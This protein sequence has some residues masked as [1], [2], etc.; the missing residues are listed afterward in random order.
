[1]S[2]L[3]PQ[4]LSTIRRASDRL[5]PALAILPL[6]HMIID[7]LSIYTAMRVANVAFGQQ[8]SASVIDSY[9]LLAF[10]P[11]VL[12]GWV[13]DRGN[14]PRAA[15][16][17]GAAM[18]VAAAIIWPW[19]PLLA[20]WFAGLGNAVFHVA[21]GS[22]CLQHASGKAAVG[23]LFVGPGDLGVVLGTFIGSG[24]WP[25]SQVLI[26]AGILLTA[27]VAF[28][29]PPAIPQP[30]PHRALSGTAVGVVIL[31]LALAV[32]CRQLI[33]GVVG[34]QWPWFSSPRE[35]I[36]IAAVAMVGKMTLGF[37]ADRWGWMRV[38]VPLTVVAA[39]L[40]AV[41]GYLPATLMATL[42]VQAAMPVTLA[43][44]L[45]VMPRYPALAFGIA[46]T[47]LWV[48]SLP[49]V[50]NWLPWPPAVIAAVQLAAGLALAVVLMM[51]KP[52]AACERSD[53]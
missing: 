30:T 36:A 42:L 2:T 33:G 10:A 1:M 31:L 23:G 13:V 17:L 14:W 46:S 29:R 19:E 51:L 11:Q 22:I 25:G 50:L 7:G 5:W 48:G 21:G 39:P 37:A 53:R 4:H 20:L 27:A 3:P 18:T 28:P 8:H 32:A 44:L 24:M 35:W 15:A 41:R 45:R 26:A 6:G 38:A 40:V 12:L 34:G 9:S 49:G 47:S 43:A 52:G 16:V